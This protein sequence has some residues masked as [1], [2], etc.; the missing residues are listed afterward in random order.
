M[1]MKIIRVE[2]PPEILTGL[3]MMQ[4]IALSQMMEL[5]PKVTLSVE[6]IPSETVQV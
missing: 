3:T 2:I 6:M 1:K 4:Q 5:L